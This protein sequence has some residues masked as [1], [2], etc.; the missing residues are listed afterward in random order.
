MLVHKVFKC[1]LCRI[2]K[3][4]DVAV[5]SA[6]TRAHGVDIYVVAHNNLAVALVFALARVFDFSKW[7]LG[8]M[9]RR[10]GGF[11]LRKL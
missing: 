1:V 4:V 5:H 10:S 9:K 8:A 11:R 6:K 3:K 2:V 7:L